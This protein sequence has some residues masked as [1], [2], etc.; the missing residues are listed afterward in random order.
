MASTAL[1]A[2]LTENHRTSQLAVKAEAT[3]L[4]L[5]LWPMLDPGDLDANLPAW[6][7][8][9]VAVLQR[10]DRQS[11]DTA[12]S[13]FTSFAQA[14]TARFYQPP[15]SKPID[16]GRIRT[17]LTIAGPVSVKGLLAKGHPLDRALQTSQ[18]RVAGQAARFALEGH[19]EMLT[20]AL[21]A[22]YGDNPPP[23]GWA[24]VTSGTPCAFCAMLASR[25]PVYSQR[26]VGFQ[27]HGHCACT[28]EPVF[29]RDQPWPG[30]SREF[31]D[32]YNQAQQQA[33]EQGT[34][35]LSDDALNVF[36]RAL[37]T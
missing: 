16:I 26:T 17:N 12:R 33:R 34:D 21:N 2:G 6:L 25:G 37:T 24:R 8:A 36:R 15:P 5:Q 9:M 4:A 10:L 27:A 13:Y 20:D 14:E 11:Q 19:R 30:R 35:G 32:L 18:V 22:D 3:R 1:G 28:A 29:R 31:N 23:R 7:E